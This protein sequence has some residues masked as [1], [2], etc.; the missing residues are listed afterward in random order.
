M[1]DAGPHVVAV[2]WRTAV[3]MS[4][5]T[6]LYLGLANLVLKTSL[7]RDF[8]AQS[9]DLRITYDSAYS[10]WP[11]R[12]KVRNLGVRFE[13]H[14]VQFF[15]GVERG[16][17]DV[18]L[19]E[20]FLRRFHA[21]RVD[22]DNVTFRMRHKLHAVGKEGPRVAAYPPIA[23]FAD[24]PLYTGPPPPPISDE[25]YA[26]WDVKVEGVTARVKEIW[27]LEYRYRGPGIARGG[28]HVK[29]ARY[30]DV[31]Q[32]TLDLDG[33]KLT[34]GD[35][36]VAEH[37]R[38]RIACDVSGSDPRKL[39]GLEPLRAITADV[40]GHFDHADLAFLDAYLGPHAA[41][42][43]GGQ[44]EL[45]LRAKIRGGAVAP[46]TRI[47][48]TSKE[49]WL[50]NGAFRV[51]G[52]AALSLESAQDPGGALALRFSA[53]DLVL[54]SQ[55]RA[56]KEARN[57]PRVE[58]VELWVRTTSELTRP[59]EMLSAELRETRVMVPD[60]GWIKRAVKARGMPELG[61]R[62]SL[63]VSAKREAKGRGSAELEVEAS[64]VTLGFPDRTSLPFKAKLTSSVSAAV[65][66][67]TEVEGSVK[68]HVDRASALLPLIS[69]SAFLREVEIQLLKL[70]DVAASGRFRVGKRSRFDLVDARSGIAR[71]RGYLLADDAGAHGAF[72]VSTPA[73]NVGIRVAPKAT[74]IRLFVTDDWLEQGSTAT[75]RGVLARPE[76]GRLSR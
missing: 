72:L 74:S 11:G 35:K 48:V 3:V 4:S 28:F 71:G 34:L 2:A 63:T 10:V 47:A 33:G 62:A 52:P 73:A 31:V 64:D 19:H 54:E 1:H 38:A 23:G 56:T 75:S 51:R 42:T 41:L 29:P 17:L 39:S 26:L 18:S 58:R 37:A 22:G 67:D 43:A 66:A 30:Y 70:D 65:A 55:Q 12:V 14:N 27:I 21:L 44:G 6:L 76:R 9:D 13:D 49:A 45:E 15:V 68:L 50:G 25:E 57:T 20:L 16:T 59:L 36:I 40:A 69:E 32:A 60:L 5:L 53:R 46:A 24:P 8:A 7:L 61:G